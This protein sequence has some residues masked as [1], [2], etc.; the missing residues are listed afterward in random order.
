MARFYS[1]ENFPQPV[2]EALRAL[3]HDVLTSRD[4]GKANQRIED[5]EVLAY[6]ALLGRAV[7]TLNRRDF[8]RL[9]E[10]GAAH[11]G[12][13]ACTADTDFH[14]QAARIDEAVKTHP[15]LTGLFVRVVK[16]NR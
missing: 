9:H 11:E 1:N 5:P 7:L 13:V 6:A 14:A 12:V 2:V 15:T 8:R 16:G 10:S 3:G 4:A